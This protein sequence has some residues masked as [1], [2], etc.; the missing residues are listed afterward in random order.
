M[1]G[2]E[3]TGPKKLYL[4]DVNKTDDFNGTNGLELSIKKWESIVEAL[5]GR[6]TR[7]RARQIE[8]ISSNHCGLCY[9]YGRV[10]SL[11]D[12]CGECPMKRPDRNGCLEVYQKADHLIYSYGYENGRKKPALLASRVMLEKLLVFKQGLRKEKK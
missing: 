10:A 12:L 8:Y 6:L 3:V 7:G 4:Y 5:E 11:A 9:E 1:S 2:N